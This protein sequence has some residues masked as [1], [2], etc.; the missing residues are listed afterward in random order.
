MGTPLSRPQ[1]NERS[2]E[3]IKS[4]PINVAAIDFGTT[5]LSL[6]YSTKG[7]DEWATSLDLGSDTSKRIPN[8]ILFKRGDDEKCQVLHIGNKARKVFMD[9]SSDK[10]ER[11]I[12]FERV[13]MLLRRDI[14]VD[15]ILDTIYLISR[16][17]F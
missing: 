17:I 10:R 5:S 4:L 13:K 14:K 3:K 2:Q 6:S 9:A 15:I 16:F 12:Y 1:Q 11:L 7:D 8:A